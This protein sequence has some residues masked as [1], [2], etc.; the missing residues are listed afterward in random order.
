MINWYL[1]GG[2]SEAI[3]IIPLDSIAAVVYLLDLIT[4]SI[5]VLITRIHYV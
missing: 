1:L 4:F 5:N 2:Q 3:I